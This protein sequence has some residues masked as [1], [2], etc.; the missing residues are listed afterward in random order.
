LRQL[1]DS[2]VS[3]DQWHDPTASPL[4]GDPSGLPPVYLM[5]G[6]DEM[7][8]DDT[9]RFGAKAIAAGVDVTFDIV[10]EMQHIYIKAAG[11]TPESDHGIARLGGYLR[12]I[13]AAAG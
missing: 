10:P 9:I 3:P 2:F 4:S 8:R 12:R 11:T 6:D 7:L 5:A 1:R 13:F